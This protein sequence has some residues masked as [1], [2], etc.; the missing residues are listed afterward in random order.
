MKFDITDIKNKDGE[1]KL[2]AE[3]PEQEEQPFKEKEQP[4][5]DEQ[6]VAE[7]E[8][9]VVEEEQ[10]VVEEERPVVE[11]ERPAAEEETTEAGTLQPI[12]TYV[13]QN[14]MIFVTLG[15]IL[16]L[17]VL[18][19]ISILKGKKKS[20]TGEKSAEVMPEE[21]LSTITQPQAEGNAVKTVPVKAASVHEQGSREDQQDSFG[22]S[23]YMEQG[24]GL[25]AVVADGM[26]GLDN[27]K[28]VSS[29]AVNTCFDVFY[30]L[31]N[32]IS[33]TDM[34]LQMAVHSNQAVNQMLK[35]SGRSGSTL[36]AA[37]I[38]NGQLHY[39]TI[40]DSH[41]YLYRGG[42]LLQL[43]REHIYR[44]ELS[45]EALNGR[46]SIHQAN[47]DPQAKSLTSYLGIGRVPYL[48]RNYEGIK[49][50]SGDKI[51]LASDGVFGTLSQEQMEEA[52]QLSAEKAAEKIGNMVAAANRPYQDNYTAVVLEYEG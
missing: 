3:I 35:V 39:L 18:L 6:P 7:E 27:G 34:L 23:D 43:N 45:L 26:G 12:I 36:V 44:E 10:P 4:V 1:V 41:I 17:L 51:L 24:K 2:P 16:V 30:S 19:V 20:N 29:L 49:L 37:I 50:V 33:H 9:P 5:A 11:E 22:I 15:V 32:Y 40:G 14:P 8:Q 46:I 21:K 28:A 25:L 42:A 31:P 38:G 47:N 52:L 48:D 13:K